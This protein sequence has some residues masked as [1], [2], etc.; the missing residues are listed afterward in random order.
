MQKKSNKLWFLFIAAVYFSMP[1]ASLYSGLIQHMPVY[2]LTAHL[3]ISIMLSFAFVQYVKRTQLKQNRELPDKPLFVL[4][5]LGANLLLAM[6]QT[7]N[8]GF[9]WLLPMIMLAISAGI[10]YA[11]VAYVVLLAQN[12]L[13]HVDAISAWELVATVIYGAFCIWLMQQKLTMRVLP[14]LFVSMLSID[15]ILQILKRQ[16]QL[17]LLKQESKQ[18]LIELVS[19][20]VLEVFIFCYLKYREGKDGSSED[21]EEEKSEGFSEDEVESESEDEVELEAESEEESFGEEENISEDEE[22][23]EASE[24]EVSEEESSDEEEDIS[25]DEEAEEESYGEEEDISEIEDEE[26]LAEESDSGEKEEMEEESASEE[27]PE[28]EFSGE[29]ESEEES[30]PEDTEKDLSDI[31]AADYSLRLRLQEYSEQLFRH[32]LRISNIAAEAAEYMDGNVLL[33]QAGGLY[34]EIGRIVDEKNYINEGERLLREEGWS[35]ELIAV[36]K[37]HTASEKPQTLEAAIVLLAD[38]IIST[39][40]YLEKAGRRKEL[41]D[42]KLVNTIFRNRIDKGNLDEAGLSDEQIEQLREYFVEQIFS[43]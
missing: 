19:V 14:Y 6:G 18:L 21:V 36:V 11:M 27:E 4:L 32:S 15:G 7:E 23:E 20:L 5:F 37:Q 41:S 3:F 38:Y 34:H 16:F 33:A 13:I 42:E 8:Y 24:E 12:I 22:P 43:I 25:E 26:E 28:G 9:L 35:E 31:L 2:E 29:E 10:E 17:A 1:V 30:T 40:D 39:S